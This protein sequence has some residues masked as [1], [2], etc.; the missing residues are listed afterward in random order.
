MYLIWMPWGFWWEK[1]KKFQPLVFGPSQPPL[2]PLQSRQD[3]L[4]CLICCCHSSVFVS[5]Y[6]LVWD[7]LLNCGDGGSVGRSLVPA[8]QHAL[9]W[10]FLFYFVCLFVCVCILCSVVYQDGFYGADIYVSIIYWYIIL[11]VTPPSPWFLP[12][13]F[14]HATSP[15]PALHT[16]TWLDA[17]LWEQIAACHILQSGWLKRPESRK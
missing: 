1:E 3:A 13:C 15:P 6:L 17:Q 11:H 10:M 4:S 7:L 8:C 5:V 14:A 12:C 9:I 2:P 16:R